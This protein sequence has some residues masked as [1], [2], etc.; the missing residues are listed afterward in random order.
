MT[1]TSLQRAIAI[2]A[3]LAAG[4]AFGQEGTAT[5][6][7]PGEIRVSGISP[8]RFN[9]THGTVFFSVHGAY[10]PSDPRDVAVIVDDRQLPAGRVT[11]T[12]RIVAAAYIMGPGRG[13]VTLRA[14]DGAGQVLTASE[15]VWSGDLTLAVEVTDALGGPVDQ[16]ELVASLVRQP[17]ST[18]LRVL[19]FSPRWTPRP[20]SRPPWWT[21]TP[22]LLRAAASPGSCRTGT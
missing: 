8:A 9:P 1:S 11:V 14:W 10:F 7:S 6:P 19:R 12:R 22:T 2:L 21:S 4:S 3:L 5:L 15:T 16:A 17:T 18:S 20:N 13:T